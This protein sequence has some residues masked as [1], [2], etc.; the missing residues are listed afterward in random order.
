[1]LFNGRQRN[2]ALGAYDHR[3]SRPIRVI[4]VDIHIVSLTRGYS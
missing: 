3:T 4:D 1:M 2:Y